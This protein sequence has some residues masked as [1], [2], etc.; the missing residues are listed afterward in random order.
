M[1]APAPDS[2]LVAVTGVLS[3]EVFSLTEPE[4]TFGRDAANTISF[5]DPALS[6]RHCVFASDADGWTLRD[7]D[8]SNG[9]FVNGVQIT[10]QRLSEGDRIAVGDS[11]LLFARAARARPSQVD[12]LEADVVAP[13]AR[14]PIEDTTYLKHPLGRGT[15][16]IERGLRAL[17]TI[18]TIINGVRSED[19]LLRELLNVLREMVPA[20]VVSI[21]LTRADGELEVIN[22]GVA[23]DRPLQVSSTVVR[24]VLAERTG[25]LSHDV[26]ASQASGSSEPWLGA[27][28]SLLC[29]P[30]IAREPVGAVYV[31]TS[32]RAAFDDDHLQLV[33][34]VA[35]MAALA[36]DNVRHLAAIEREAER[37]HADLQLS[38]NLVGSSPPMERVY[39]LVRR[40]ART[41]TT[42]LLTGESGTGKELAARAIHLNSPRAR[43]PFVAINCA[44][45]TE[46][47]LESELFGHERGAFTGAVTQKRGRLEIAD[48]GTLFLDEVGELAPILQS[49]LLRVLQ[50]R[51]FERVGGTRPLNV[52]IRL[53]SATNRNLGADVRAT[54][55]R[56]DLYFR[57]NVVSIAMPP[58]RE[59]PS[60]IPVLARH[61]LNRFGPKAG[62][63]I[64]GISTMALTCLQ[65]YDWP[66][67]VRELENAIERAVVLGS[68]A[69]ILPHDLPEQIAEATAAVA[70]PEAPDS[71]H[72]AVLETKRKAILQAFRSADGS[73][74]EA[75]RILKVHP[76][77][78]HRLV[79]NLG[80][81]LKREG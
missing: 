49:K 33:T 14:L 37:H 35:R 56:E 32:Q 45:L 17:L 24:R 6:R 41:D 72:A 23:V 71:F 79:R 44:A 51:E 54:R 10:S 53:I 57:L 7:L 60:D 47:L 64:N 62:R 46:S 34:A 73:Y 38:H 19:A 8:S 61:F 5:P 77:Y 66:G 21:V 12:L 28:R 48:G 68:S 43:R 81:T 69:E 40:V 4:V 2:R 11:I 76:N 78:L 22:E 20:E 74:T 27:A 31:A 42:V 36:I 25:L 70:G 58:L 75:A 15:P 26:V 67:N 29:V 30:I 13:T 1:S 9:T 50:E 63:R 39:E 3:G 16:R 59:R 52:D 65:T 18:S 80:L 55:F